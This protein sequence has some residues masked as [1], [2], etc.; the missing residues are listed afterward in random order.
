MKQL[1]EQADSLFGRSKESKRTN[2]AWLKYRH[3]EIEKLAL[4][5]DF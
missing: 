1:L 4:A 3:T 5:D 2:E